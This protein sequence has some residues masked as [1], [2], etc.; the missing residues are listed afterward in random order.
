MIMS[1]RPSGGLA[2]MATPSACVPPVSWSA[3]YRNTAMY[4][5]Y[6]STGLGGSHNDCWPC[7]NLTCQAQ[8]AFWVC[9]WYKHV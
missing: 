1:R 8:G 4:K 3:W 5:A 9:L 6:R 7:A 2:R